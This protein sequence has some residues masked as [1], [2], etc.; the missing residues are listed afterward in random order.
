[1][2]AP[3]VDD[4]YRVVG[5]ITVD[6]VVDVIRE[7]AE[8]SLMSAAGLDEEDDM[9][10]P[11]FKSARRRALWLGI[12]LGTA[13]LAAAVVDQFQTTIDKIVLLAVLMPVV[14]SMGGVAGTQ[15]LVIITRAMALGQVD[16]TNATRILKKELAVGLLNGVGW[17]IVVGTFTYLWFGDWRIGGVIAA[18]MIINLFIA[19]FSGFGI[20]LLL[21]RMRIDPAIA[22][23]VVLT[24]VTDVVGYMTFLGLGAALLL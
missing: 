21:K 4:D 20:P 8:H 19:A 23:G 10:A 1:L 9:F 6:D 16:K 5:R 2:S 17:S 7:E 13:F 12:N 11:V 18:A 22:G 14:P 3:V 24:T 15:S